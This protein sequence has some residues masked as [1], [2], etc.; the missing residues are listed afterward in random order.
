MSRSS[1]RKILGRTAIALFPLLFSAQGAAAS[2]PVAYPPE[3]VLLF[4]AA[5]CA[6]CHGELAHLAEIR[7]GA[8]PYRVLVVPFDDSRATMA[9]LQGVPATA[10]LLPDRKAQRR[11][12]AMVATE[13]PGLPFSVAIDGQGHVCA[14]QAE[15][16]T[17]STARALVARCRN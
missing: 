9:M 2:D 15:A 14:T 1:R 5:W 17:A 12:A 11:M 3:T 8:R 7:D 16:L 13:S 6:P 10:R 4:V